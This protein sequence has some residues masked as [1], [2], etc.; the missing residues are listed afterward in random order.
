M[1]G[2]DFLEDPAESS[3]RL[4]N[5]FLESLPRSPSEEKSRRDLAYQRIYV[6]HSRIPPRAHI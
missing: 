1:L 4:N 2:R 6:D 3:H 5:R